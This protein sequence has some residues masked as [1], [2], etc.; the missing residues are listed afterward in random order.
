MDEQPDIDLDI[1]IVE[2]GLENPALATM[3][4]AAIHVLARDGGLETLTQQAV[5]SFVWYELPCEYGGTAEVKL[6][7]VAALGRLFER[8]GMPRYAQVCASPTT[9]TVV[10]A[11]DKG[12][13]RGMLAYRRA[14]ERSG[15][16]PPHLPELVWG[17][18]MGPVEASAFQSTAAALELAVAARLLR[19]GA[20][21]WRK[22][23]QELA[24]EHL[25]LPHPEFGGRAW[26]A[27]V[28]AE[29]FAYWLHGRSRA[30]TRLVGAVAEQVLASAGPMPGTVPALAPLQW[31]LSLAVDGLPLTA[32]GNWSRAL[33]AEVA[34]RFGWWPY[35]RPPRGEGEVEQVRRLHRLLGRLG[36]L[37]RAG[38][39]EELTWIGQALQQDG[40]ILWRV[41][42]R[43][44]GLGLDFD[45]HL[46]ELV[47]AA[48]LAEPS[49]DTYEVVH[50]VRR[51]LADEGWRDHRGHLEHEAAYA[52]FRAL[53]Q[54]A[55]PLG[56]FD[57][58]VW[59][60]DLRLTVAG[61]ELALE[62][63]RVRATAPREVH[64]CGP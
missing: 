13:N 3:A 25:T 11:Y 22:V 14:E 51:I 53:L 32:R 21:G 4:A 38:A 30:R 57:E 48:L 8:V 55:L 41:V 33:V 52:S 35:P 60:G 12:V 64:L 39:R 47:F 49:V 58:Q 20:R 23:Q 28:Y 7:L 18:T 62:A 9:A 5:Q 43:H 46:R 56:M 1:A 6:A 34:E 36:A 40:T 45:A 19:P 29:R 2:L 15:V 31:V 63:L 59:P 42:A 54:L 24:W 27:G 10:R 50:R 26:L 61:R 37:R 44:L 16:R 17:R